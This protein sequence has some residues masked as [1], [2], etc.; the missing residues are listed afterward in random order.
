MDSDLRQALALPAQVISLRRSIERRAAFAQCN[1]E[2]G[3]D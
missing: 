2:S 3:L 1:R